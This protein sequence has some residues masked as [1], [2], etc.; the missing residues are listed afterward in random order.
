[1][2][3]ERT[4]M[5]NSS[6]SKFSTD[7]LSAL[8]L[9][10]ED[11]SAEH[12]KWAQNLGAKAVELGLGTLDLAKI[13][14]SALTKTLTTPMP[15]SDENAATTSA[16][17]FFY[18]ALTPIEKTHRSALEAARHLHEISSHLNQRT[19]EL[20]ASQLKVRKETKERKSSEAALHTSGETAAEL[21]DASRRLEVELCELTRRSLSASETE[22]EQMSLHLQ[23]KI[24]QTLLGIHVR[25]LSLKKLISISHE[26]FAEQIA[27]TQGLLAQSIKSIGS[28]A[29]ALDIHREN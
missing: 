16:S 11:G 26:D 4:N 25:L 23:G 14:D 12:L 10:L 15:G 28:F 3:D 13:H 17:N 7:Y 22:R 1:M 19:K 24:A 9:H 8:R 6:L 27:T 2:P 21:I 5:N 20:A 29:S 18:E